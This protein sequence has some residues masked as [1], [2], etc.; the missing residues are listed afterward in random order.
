M[1][2]RK[3][4]WFKSNLSSAGHS[5]AGENAERFIL[6]ETL[7][8]LGA[9]AMPLTVHVVLF[10]RLCLRPNEGTRRAVKKRSVIMLSMPIVARL[11]S[12]NLL[13]QSTK[14]AQVAWR[15]MRY[16]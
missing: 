10:C 15:P 13:I 9:L 2:F 1:V 8:A 7:M 14:T 11:G 6:I 12:Y 3:T 16:R 5:P 4:C